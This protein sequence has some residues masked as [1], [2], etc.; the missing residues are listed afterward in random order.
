MPIIDKPKRY[1]RKRAV[2]ARYGD[3]CNKTLERMVLD[4]RV[5]PPEYFGDSRTPFWEES[6][7]DA[8]DRMVVMRPRSR[9][10]SS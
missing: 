10:A 2:R 3:C 5:P 1:L 9:A 6:N 7:L 4:G 8:H